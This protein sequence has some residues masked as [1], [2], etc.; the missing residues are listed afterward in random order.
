MKDKYKYLVTYIYK[1]EG[2]TGIS[3]RIFTAKKKITS[4]ADLELVYTFIEV[5]GYNNPV[6]LNF[7]LLDKAWGIWDW[8]V[9]IVEL[10]LL[11]LC[12]LS[13]IATIFG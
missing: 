6:L 2:G 12:I 4:A 10:I 3:S 11:V 9:A 7:I 13:V 8:F 5:D 1:V